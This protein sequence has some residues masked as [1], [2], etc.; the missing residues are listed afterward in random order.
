MTVAA[1]GGSGTLTL[2]VSGQ[3]YTGTVNF[4]TCTGLPLGTTCSFNPPSVT[5]AASTTLTVL[6]PL[7]MSH[8]RGPLTQ[9]HSGSPAEDSPSPECS[10]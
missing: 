7:L 6:T 1:P 4:A 3:N 8:S 5:G 10:C 9:D 2:S